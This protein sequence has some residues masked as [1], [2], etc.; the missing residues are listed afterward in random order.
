MNPAAIAYIYAVAG[1]PGQ[2]TTSAAFSID[3]VAAVPEPATLA[4]LGIT[5]A[6]IGFARRRAK[7]M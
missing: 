6:G 7:L 4:L 1:V 3:V 2:Q 5:L